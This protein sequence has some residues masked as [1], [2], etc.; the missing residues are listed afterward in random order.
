MFS[1]SSP[2]AIGLYKGPLVSLVIVYFSSSNS[3][4][5]FINRFLYQQQDGLHVI[6]VYLLLIGLVSSTSTLQVR[7]RS[8]LGTAATKPSNR[9]SLNSTCV[10]GRNSDS[11]ASTPLC[12]SNPTAIQLET[13]STTNV[14]KSKSYATHGNKTDLARPAQ[15][16]GRRLWLIRQHLRMARR[17][18]L[19]NRH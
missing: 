7:C 18:A 3:H 5:S 10:T 9:P 14:A 17:K 12:V 16:R 19:M 8:N 13:T 4:P 2:N 11:S 6:Y 15:Q 1:S